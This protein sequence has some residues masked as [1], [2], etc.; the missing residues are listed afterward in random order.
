MKLTAADV[1]NHRVALGAPEETVSDDNLKN[2]YARFRA[3]G[4]HAYYVCH[5]TPRRWRKVGDLA[6]VGALTLEQARAAAMDLLVKLARGTDPAV[7]KAKADGP[8][9]RL[10]SVVLGDPGVMMW[11]G[12]LLLRDGEPVG[13]LTSAAWGESV[14]A[15]VG[16]GYLRDP[17]GEAVTAEFVRTGQYEVN[18]GGQLAAGAVSLRPPYDAARKNVS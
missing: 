13:Q 3:T 12:E 18:V 17:A 2:G 1:R 6:G 7:E 10:V 14:G 16:L 15:A 5:G 8:R 9:R 4:A 11:G